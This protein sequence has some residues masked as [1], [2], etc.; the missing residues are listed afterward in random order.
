MCVA[1]VIIIEYYKAVN[2]KAYFF[3]GIL[4]NSLPNN[5]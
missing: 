4:K 2:K 1:V 3:N 5:L